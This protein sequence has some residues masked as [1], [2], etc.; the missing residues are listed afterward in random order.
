MELVQPIRDVEKIEA[1]KRILGEGDFG[2]RNRALFIAGINS[3]LR[4]SDLLTLKVADVRGTHISI[5][6]G[7]TDKFKRF[8]INPTL[9][10]ELDE[11][12]N[13]ENLSDND[14]LF[15][16][17]QGD[18]AI[19]RVQAYR[20]LNKAASQIGIEE[21][22]TH[23]LRKTMGYFHYQ[24][25]KDVAILQK[26]FNHSAPSVTLR[27]IGYEQDQLDESMMNFGL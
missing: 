19:T 4:I 14:W 18:K 1:M 26:L 12:I 7:K 11:Y 27:Y 17:R 22:G 23:T 2:P 20:I 13:G 25:N 21:I 6:E 16:S 3:G 15:P 9:R 5:R 8:V 10:K 24:R